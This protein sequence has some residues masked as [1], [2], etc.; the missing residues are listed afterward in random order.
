MKVIFPLLAVTL[1]AFVSYTLY[2]SSRYRTDAIRSLAARLGMHYLGSAFPKSLTLYGTPFSGAS[3]V[4]NVID[5]EPR[6][7]RVIAFDCQVGVGKHSW[8]RTI[9]A[10]ESEISIVGRLPSLPEMTADRSG[11][12]EILYRPQKRFNLRGTGLM[13]VEELES[14]LN[15]VVDVSSVNRRN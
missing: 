10:I 9:V 3:K 12:W 8:R 14:N 15:A 7:T 11:R 2:I 1:V 13:P 6:G 5:G 4:W